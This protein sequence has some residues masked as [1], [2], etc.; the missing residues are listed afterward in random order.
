MALFVE[1]ARICMDFVHEL[2]QIGIK[3]QTVD[4]GGGLSSSYD[5]PDEPAEFSFQAYKKALGP[6]HVQ[7]NCS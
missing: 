6:D 5:S 7:V 2:E 4:I 1:G 3:I